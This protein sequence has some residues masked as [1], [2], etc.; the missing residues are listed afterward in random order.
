MPVSARL[1]RPLS[2]AFLVGALVFALTNPFCCCFLPAFEAEAAQREMA[3]DAADN[4]CP[5]KL[6]AVP[7]EGVVQAVFVAT[8]AFALPSVG[9]VVPGGATEQAWLRALAWASGPPLA[10]LC[11]LLI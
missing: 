4:R 6:E 11:V 10:R 7:S 8:T 1:L 9:K 3:W 5:G 2:P